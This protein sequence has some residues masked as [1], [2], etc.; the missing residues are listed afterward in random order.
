MCINPINYY[1]R[2]KGN[3]IC[4]KNTKYGNKSYFR[5]KEIQ[6]CK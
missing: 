4:P 3:K 5:I 6:L 1:S 2:I